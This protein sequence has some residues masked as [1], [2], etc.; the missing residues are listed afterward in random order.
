MDDAANGVRAT[1]ENSTSRSMTLD[2][3]QLLY[4][5]ETVYDPSTPNQ[6]RKDATAYLDQAKVQDDA[7]S[8][9]FMLANDR[10]Q[11]PTTR[12]FGLSLLEFSIKYRWDSFNVEQTQM[13][14]TWIVQLASTVDVSEPLY[15]RNKIAQLWVDIAERSWTTDWQEMDEAL[16]KLWQGNYAQ[17]GLVLRT[18][19]TLSDTVFSAEGSTVSP[20]RNGDLGKACVEIFLSAAMLARAL[21]ERDFGYV[22][23]CGDEGWLQ[24][25]LSRLE[26]CLNEDIGND[27]N[28]ALF[29]V[30]TLAVLQ[31]VMPWILLKAVARSNCVDL[32]FKCL[33]SRDTSIQLVSSMPPP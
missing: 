4:A 18:L 11:S 22:T 19:E 17:Q 15:Y 8:L 20:S 33:E 24:R 25:L 6:T 28:V 23:R 16:C 9:G 29:V 5:L 30:R 3:S 27:R 26:Q 13:L 32:I 14:R 10:G 21:P 2:S 12:H 7:P 31:T 1:A